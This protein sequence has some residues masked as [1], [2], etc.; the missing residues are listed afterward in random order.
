MPSALVPVSGS[1]ARQMASADPKAMVNLCQRMRLI[2]Q[3]DAGALSTDAAFHARILTELA[4]GDPKRGIPPWVS[5][6]SCPLSCDPT[7][8][9]ALPH[10]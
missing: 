2:Q 5:R 9:P 1:A 7:A 3:M 6:S 8:T 10:I 4:L